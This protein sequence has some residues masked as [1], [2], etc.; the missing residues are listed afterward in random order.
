[1]II[2]PSH[3]EPHRDVHGV[4]SSPI[5]LDHPHTSLFHQ[6]LTYGVQRLYNTFPSL[7]S[8]SLL[9][10]PLLPTYTP[11]IHL[12]RFE[13][14]WKRPAPEFISIESLDSVVRGLFAIC[15]SRGTLRPICTSF[16]WYC[17]QPEDVDRRSTAP[18]SPSRRQHRTYQLGMHRR[19]PELL[20]T[21]T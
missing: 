8:L 16:E 17:N 13:I 21:H 6:P 9:V 19:G 20:S 10:T 4:A 3:I 12:P 2:S 1:M 5:A 11:A 18:L 14:A 15:L 7:S